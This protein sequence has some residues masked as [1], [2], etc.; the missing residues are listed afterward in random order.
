MM[1]SAI[2]R[3]QKRENMGSWSKKLKQEVL[4]EDWGLDKTLKPEPA[5]RTHGLVEP[6]PPSSQP[7][8]ALKKGAEMNIEGATASYNEEKNDMESSEAGK[9]PETILTI[10]Q[11]TIHS[12]KEENHNREGGSL[13]TPKKQIVRKWSCGKGMNADEQKPKREP[14]WLTGWLIQKPRPSL[15]QSARSFDN[16]RVKDR[17]T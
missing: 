15:E 4:R 8:A 10:P 7:L 2:K 16:D 5:H 11:P 14:P 3:E 1:S 6:P 17:V 9:P 12:A 13:T